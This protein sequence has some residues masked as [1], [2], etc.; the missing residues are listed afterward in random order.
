MKR[1]A[2]TRSIVPDMILHNN[3][4]SS[5]LSCWALAMACAPTWPPPP[6]VDLPGVEDLLSEP[7]SV[8]SHLLFLF[9]CKSKER[10]ITDFDVQTSYCTNN[11]HDY[12]SYI[13]GNIFVVTMFG[14][15]L[16]KN[17]NG[18]L[19]LESVVSVLLS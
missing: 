11:Y 5:L 9:F 2:C 10:T 14:G 19:A 17:L 4:T 12:T 1:N 18:P 8:T 15:L 13:A 7:F 3:L 16:S 6:P